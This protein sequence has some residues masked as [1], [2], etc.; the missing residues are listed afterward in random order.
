[1]GVAVGYMFYDTGRDQA[2]IKSREG[3]LYVAASLQGYLM[4]IFETY[5]LTIDMPIFD[6]EASDGYVEPAAFIF[7]RRLAKL[8][9]EDLPVPIILSTLIYFMAGLDRQ[10]SKVFIFFGITILN[11]YLAVLCATVCVVLSRDFAIASLIASLVYTLQSLASGLIVQVQ[12]MPVYISWTRWI[13]YT[14]RLWPP[15][16]FS[17]PN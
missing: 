9:I 14:V 10:V 17:H 3:C 12:T 5:R 4:L 1:M 11:H 6:R 16:A 8:P 15:L 2:G 13:T 7:S